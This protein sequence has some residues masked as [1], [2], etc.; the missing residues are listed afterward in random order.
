MTEPIQLDNARYASTKEQ[1][2]AVLQEAR[3]GRDMLRSV[4]KRLSLL[5]DRRNFLEN[6][7]QEVAIRREFTEEPEPIAIPRGRFNLFEVSK[8]V[9]PQDRAIESTLRTKKSRRWSWLFG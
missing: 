6:R 9:R 4:L 5:D 8:Q 1:L 2:D 7:L 3:V